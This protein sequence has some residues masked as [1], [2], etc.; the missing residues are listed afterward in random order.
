MRVDFRHDPHC[1]LAVVRL[2][3]GESV[4]ARPQTFVSATPNVRPSAVRSPSR[5]MRRGILIQDV[6]EAKDAPGEIVL[7]A[8]HAGELLRIVV[9]GR[10]I[11]PDSAFLCAE[12]EM[13]VVAWEKSYRGFFIRAQGPMT[14]E[15]RGEVFLGAFGTAR[16]V[17]VGSG[18]VVAADHVLAFDA[19]LAFALWTSRLYRVA[20]GKWPLVY[21]FSGTGRLWLRT[22]RLATVGKRLVSGLS[23]E[24]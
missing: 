17:E 24:G 11:F 10:L 16:E 7:A 19:T 3:A 4:R 22:R 8:P 20:F 21:R 18:I 15:G 5:L 14:A 6:F 12:P 13:R 9:D 1:P 23:A 2:A